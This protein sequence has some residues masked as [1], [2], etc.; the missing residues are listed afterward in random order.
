M[1]ALHPR[2]SANERRAEVCRLLALGLRQQADCEK[3]HP[4]GAT[5][6]WVP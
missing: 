6:G 2:M 1:N 3:R 5:A 4:T